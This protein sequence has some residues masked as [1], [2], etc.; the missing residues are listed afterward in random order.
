[1]LS[2]IAGRT[3][4]L[5]APLSERLR[6]AYAAGGDCAVIVP[7]QYTLQAERDLIADLGVPGFFRLEV[8]SPSRLMQRVRD[9]LGADARVG[10]DERG[11]NMTVARALVLSGSKLRYYRSAAGKPGLVTKMA[12]LISAFKEAG[13]TPA[14]LLEK[15]EGIG[16]TALESKLR[17]VAAVYGTY[18][19]LLEGQ[20]ADREDLLE[21]MLSRIAKGRPFAGADVFIYGFDQLSESLCRLAACLAAQAG[22]VCVALVAQGEQEEDGEAFAR[23]R[24]GLQ[25]LKETMEDQ[26]LPVDIRWLP[27]ERLRAPDEVA[28]IEKYLLRPNAPPFG[29]PVTALRLFA[30]QTPHAEVRFAAREALAAIRRGT[31][32]GDI[33]VLC[34]NLGRYSGLI[35][36]VFEEYRVPFYIS[37][38]T[39]VSSHAVVRCLLA[40]LRCAAEGWRRE[41]VLDMAKSGFMPLAVEEGWR[42]ENY[43]LKYGISGRRWLDPFE[44][45][46]PGEREE[47]EALRQRLTAPALQLQRRLAAARNPGDSLRAVIG[48]LDDTGAYSRIVRLEGELLAAGMPVEAARTRQVWKRLVGMLEQMHALMDDERIPIR[49]FGGWLEAGLAGDEIA[50]LPPVS[51]C[52]QCGEIGR[53]MVHSPRVALVLGLNDGLFAEGAEELLT[54]EEMQATE[55]LFEVRMEVTPRAREEAALLDLWKALCAPSER[56]CLSYSLAN[57]EGGA[58]RPLSWLNRVR[59]LL[60]GLREEGG[61][62][63]GT[64]DPFPSAPAPALDAIA[65]LL[66]E[67]R[68]PDPWRDAWAWLCADPDWAPLAERLARA[69]G[70]EGEARSVG[71]SVASGLFDTRVVSVSR[72]EKYAQC[73]FSH[74]VEYGLRPQRRREWAVEPSDA[75]LLLHEAMERFTRSA[76]RIGRWPHISRAECDAAMDEAFRPLTQGW[77]ALPFADTARAR[78]ASQGYLR[79]LRRMAWTLTC[80]ARSSFFRPDSSEARFGEPGGLPPVVLT[81]GD[82][83]GAAVRGAIDRIDRC[84]GEEG[85]YLRVIDYKSSAQHLDPARIWWGLQLQLLIYLKA[86]ADAAPG[87][88]PAG[89]FYQHLADP[90]A[91]TE[92]PEKAEEK[93]ARELRLS[94]FALSDPK[95]VRLMD[96]SEP[97]YSI[98]PLFGADGKPLK[99]KPLCSAEEIGLLLRHAVRAASGI[100]RSIR[101][102]LIPRSPVVDR[103]GRRPCD[104]CEYAGICRRDPLGGGAGERA[105]P[106]MS[107][108][109]LLS[110]CASGEEPP[111]AP[112]PDTGAFPGL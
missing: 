110:R 30:A 62:A 39:P 22:S 26:K 6:A 11:R 70:R 36:S 57:E 13:I 106:S 45:G 14:A 101:G 68:L 40:A 88:Q 82:G 21:D 77:E 76:D 86:A 61:A 97:P 79:L 27:A 85:S 73:P 74:F 83:S 102:G 93:I 49:Y 34:G 98:V 103:Y 29:G 12:P 35:A 2:V 55:Q 59:D 32:P 18:E 52:V 37:D 108:E 92:D 105:L 80:G 4:R 81:P 54:Q 33:A 48:F 100:A 17:D 66:R 19:A 109:A 51:E 67:G 46:E 25:R 104:Y 9:R 24:Q 111:C 56:L 15:A 69:A 28:H 99:N 63:G 65:P 50:S 20:F 53:L 58:L 84:G 107:L 44:R 47:A 16:E 91:R 8:L 1:M 72:L 42:I 90:V 71:K 38:K 7:E 75:G 43:A 64:Q 3:G 94:G 95:V 96:F 60:P 112:A 5:W 31:S 10:I 87:A 23:V 41:D 89:A 78:N